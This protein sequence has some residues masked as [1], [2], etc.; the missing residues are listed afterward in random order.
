M[1]II[2]T[3][4][5]Y[6]FYSCYSLLTLVLLSSLIT[7]SFLACR[8]QITFTFLVILPLCALINDQGFL[9]P[10]SLTIIGTI[11]EAF[12]VVKSF[13]YDHAIITFPTRSS[14]SITSIVNIAISFIASIDPAIKFSIVT[15]CFVIVNIEFAS[16]Y[17]TS[18]FVVS[19]FI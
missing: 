13:P 11:V 8:F 4:Y 3:I 15:H 17:L 5:I 6:I 10:T 16:T 1:Q 14:F 19:P 7:T 9:L 18:L 2:S 12:S